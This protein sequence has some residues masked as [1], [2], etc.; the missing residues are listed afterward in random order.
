M[1]QVV[2]TVVGVRQLPPKEGK[3]PLLAVDVYDGG[4][5]YKVMFADGADAKGDFR[6]MFESGVA[7]RVSA[8]QYGVQYWAVQ[9]GR[10]A[11]GR[12]E[13]VPF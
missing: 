10:K 2:G 11:A 9:Q 13:E 5:F 4:E 1:L 6:G 8:G 12:T 7:V 3:S